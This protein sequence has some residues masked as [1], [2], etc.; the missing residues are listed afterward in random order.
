MLCYE[1]IEDCV[2]FGEGAQFGQFRVAV[3][4][5]ELESFQVLF[6]ELLE[7]Q[8]RFDLGARREHRKDGTFVETKIALDF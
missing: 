2:D 4:Q 8:D 1:R 6:A 5:L 7:L 3:C